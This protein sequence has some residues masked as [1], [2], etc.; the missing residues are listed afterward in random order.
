MTKKSQIPDLIIALGKALGNGYVI[1]A[2]I[3]RKSVME[4]AQGTFISS[5][6]WTERIGSAAALKT[7]EVMERTKSWDYI[8]LKGGKIW[9]KWQDLADK[10]DIEIVHWGI[11]ALTGFSFLSEKALIYKTYITQEV[12]KRRFLASSGIYVSVAHTDELIDQYFSILDPLFADIANYERGDKGA[13]NLD[14][15]ICHSG[16]KRLN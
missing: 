6:F 14:G 3:G 2:V 1:T 13:L 11:P 15:P 7:L 16:F 4:A 12:L 9:K 5:T 8:T 10:Y